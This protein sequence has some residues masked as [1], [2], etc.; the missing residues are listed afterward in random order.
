MFSQTFSVAGPSTYAYAYFSQAVWYA[1]YQG[2]A[3]CDADPDSCCAP[4][5][6]Y[7]YVLR[8]TGTAVTCELSVSHV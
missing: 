3:P 8:F 5:P 4:R 1:V 6:F 2:F 7:M